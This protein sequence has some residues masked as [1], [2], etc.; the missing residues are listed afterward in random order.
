MIVD[1]R[2]I[3][4]IENKW[5]PDAGAI[6]M[7]KRLWHHANDG[8]R[9]SVDNETASEN[10]RSRAER[11]PPE[12]VADYRNRICSVAAFFGSKSASVGRRKAENRKEIR[13][14]LGGRNNLRGRSVIP[15]YD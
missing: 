10:I 3:V 12:I 11:V 14:D 13:G 6:R 5:E 4:R 2:Q 15:T 7:P 9:R 1:C 8:A